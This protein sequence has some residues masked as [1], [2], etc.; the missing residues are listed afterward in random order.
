MI[1]NSK[2]KSCTIFLLAVGLLYIIVSVAPPPVKSQENVQERSTRHYSID[3][4]EVTFDVD[5][6]HNATFHAYGNVLLTFE[7]G[8][9]LWVLEAEMVEFSG[10]L[11]ENDHLVPR[12]AHAQGDINL[13]GPA[14]T[15]TAPGSI[16]I[17]ITA[18]SA[19]SDST[20]FTITALSVTTD[21]TDI[22]VIFADGELTTDSL[23]LNEILENNVSRTIV[24]TDIQ[25]VATLRLTETTTVEENGESIGNIF[26]SLV[27]DFA[28]I[29]V[30]TVRTQFIL[31]DHQAVSLDCPD[32][33]IVRTDQNT[34]SMSRAYITF[35]PDTLEGPDGVELL[36][37]EDTHVKAAYLYLEYPP[38][39][40]M[41][42]EFNGC[43]PGIPMPV[44]PEQAFLVTI[45][46]PA[47]TFSAEIINVT[48]NPDGTLK[49]NAIGRACFELPVRLIQDSDTSEE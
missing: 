49:I 6:Q 46:N 45:T 24:D 29:T 14:L 26:S 32:P 34:L 22:H 7:V 23:V 47:G 18:L 9:N 33:T 42:V 44:D 43:P 11:D 25:T 4:D 5:D 15:L 20:D 31:I 21:S 38:E 27:F 1:F 19:S 40:G 12:Y 10:E 16:D 28:N 36:V 39:G 37:G 35:D 48:V 41:K 2:M 13:T 8:E 3:G 17:V 30:E